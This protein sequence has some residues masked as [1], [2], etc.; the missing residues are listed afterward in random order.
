MNS[1][2][3]TVQI[4]WAASASIFKD[5]LRDRCLGMRIL[6]YPIFWST[7]GAMCICYSATSASTFSSNASLI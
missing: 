3:S 7:M 2:A 4:S 1:T 5:S 6:S